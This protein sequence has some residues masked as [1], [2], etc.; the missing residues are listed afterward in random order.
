MAFVNNATF[1]SFK[2]YI[3]PLKYLQVLGS[4]LNS[5]N[6]K[7]SFAGTQQSD[8]RLQLQIYNYY[9]TRQSSQHKAGKFPERFK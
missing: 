6:I 7:L 3:P 8:S 5:I 1:Y 9:Q 2:L 4:Q